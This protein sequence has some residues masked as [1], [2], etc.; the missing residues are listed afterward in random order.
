MARSLLVVSP[1]AVSASAWFLALS[2]SAAVTPESITDFTTVSILAMASS[3]VFPGATST[4]R[5]KRPGCSL[6]SIQAPTSEAT[7]FS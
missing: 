1:R 3:W 7:S 2:T 6:S 5:F 4:H